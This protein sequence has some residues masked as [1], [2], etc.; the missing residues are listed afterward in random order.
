MVCIPYNP[1]NH[2]NALDKIHLGFGT[3]LP[4]GEGFIEACL[5]V[6]LLVFAVAII[7]IARVWYGSGL[8]CVACVSGQVCEE[9][10]FRMCVVYST[11]VFVKTIF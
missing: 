11:T 7:C 9:I 2:H 8:D 6:L 3:A 5:Q 1:Y 10:V 4:F